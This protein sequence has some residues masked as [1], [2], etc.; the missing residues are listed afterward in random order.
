MTPPPSTVIF[1]RCLE[2]GG[3]ERQAVNLALG[4]RRRG[5]PAAV[6]VFYPGGPLQAELEQAGAPVLS[7]DKQGR[8]DL[9]SFLPRLAALLR[10]RR[11]QVLY[12]FLDAPNLL[13]A[14]LKPL[15]PGTKLVWGLRASN[16]DLS[17]YDRFS[18]FV[19]GLA[20]RLAGVPDLIIANSQAGRDFHIGRGYPSE[21]LAVEPNGVDVQRFRPDPAAGAELR[22]AWGVER[23]QRLI[24]LAGRL[25]PMKDHETFLRAAAGAV[26]ERRDLRFVCLGGG[27]EQEL[28]RLQAMARDLGLGRRVVWAGAWADMPAAYNALDLLASTSAFGEGFSNAVSEAMACGV[29]CVV[30]R[31]GDSALI[32]NDP[33]LVVPPGDWREAARR[34]LA[35]LDLPAEDYERMC[36]RMRKRV[37]E[38]Y[39]AERMVERTARRLAALAAPGPE[40]SS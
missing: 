20:R 3:A 35:V 6:L 27:P 37:M 1:L 26:R 8:W 16:M 9:F 36:V 19:F 4:L 2:Y 10:S 25:D 29:P 21:K 33:D 40:A 31:V 39:S 22:R 5:W 11:P 34:W 23:S 32:V 28:R 24:G 13:A 12:S 7:P 14:A 17:R 15:L 38:N 30:S 18:R